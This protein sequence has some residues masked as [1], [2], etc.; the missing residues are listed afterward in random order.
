[1]IATRDARNMRMI[2]AMWLWILLTQA[3]DII[4]TH[5]ILSLNMGR[6]A[7]PVALAMFNSAGYAATSA[8]KILVSLA[9]W[10]VLRSIIAGGGR[11]TWLTWASSAAVFV[12]G[13]LV[14]VNNFSML[15]AG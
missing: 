2:D 1:M 15:V 11:H 3:G 10:W 7:N 12:V 13:T 4:S 8:F 9:A 5:A 6:E 14:V